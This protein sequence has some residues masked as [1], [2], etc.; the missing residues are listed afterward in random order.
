MKFLNY[1]GLFFLFK[2][3]VIFYCAN[4]HITKLYSLKHVLSVYSV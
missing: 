2:N 3:V 4:K 1:I